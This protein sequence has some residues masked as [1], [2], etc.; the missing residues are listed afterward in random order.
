LHI[1]APPLAYVPAL[2]TVHDGEPAEEE[3]PTA[4]VVQADAPDDEYEPARHVSHGDARPALEKE[5]DGQAVHTVAPEF[6][7]V[8]GEHCWATAPNAQEDPAGH[9]TTV[10]VKVRPPYSADPSVVIVTTT[11]LPYRP[12]TDTSKRVPEVL[13]KSVVDRVSEANTV[14]KSQLVSV[15]K[16]EKRRLMAKRPV[17]GTS[18][19]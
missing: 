8:P 9:G 16:V 15:T 3:E 1:V 7:D 14:A 4:H 10:A 2:H 17:G 5:P 11:A 13:L 19:M 12:E 18:A 6:E